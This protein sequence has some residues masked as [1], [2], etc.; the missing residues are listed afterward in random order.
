M[1]LYEVN[2]Q[3]KIERETDFV[4]NQINNFTIKVCSNLCNMNVRF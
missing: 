4:F 1:N 2:K 3:L